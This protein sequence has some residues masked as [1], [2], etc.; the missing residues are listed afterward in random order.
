M[1]FEENVCALCDRDCAYLDDACACPDVRESVRTT[2]GVGG[3]S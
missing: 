2:A 1:I 3:D